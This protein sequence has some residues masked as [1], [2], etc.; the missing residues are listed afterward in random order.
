MI[1][2]KAKGKGNSIPFSSL[3][4]IVEKSSV[5]RQHRIRRPTSR[6]WRLKAKVMRSSSE[7]VDFTI[8]TM[9]KFEGLIVLDSLKQRDCDGNR[10]DND[11]I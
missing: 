1:F 7:I 6:F 11:W 2:T 5:P 10:S 8:L 3:F 4:A 9:V